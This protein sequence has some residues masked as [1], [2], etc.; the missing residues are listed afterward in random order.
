MEQ[1]RGYCAA[2]DPT[3]DQLVADVASD[4]KYPADAKSFGG[5]LTFTTGTGKYAGI[6]GGGTFTCHGR[7]F[8]TAAE[9]TY[10]NYCTNSGSYKI[11]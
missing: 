5:K 7:E 8:R 11:P 9:G 4:E 2:T 1:D 10:A 3:G 6:S